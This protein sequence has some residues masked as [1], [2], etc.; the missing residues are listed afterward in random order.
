[1]RI[2]LTLVR[3][4]TTRED[5]TVT[6]DA[7]TSVGELAE[8]L[9]GVDALPPRSR[10]T[11]KVD[12]PGVPDP[13]VLDPQA[14]LG[15]G[16]I[17]SGA[18]VAPTPVPT[19]GTT[20]P[21]HGAGRFGPVP[22]NRSPR[23]QDRYAGITLDVPTVPVEQDPPDFPVI[24]LIAPILMGSAMYSITGSP[25]SLL[26]VLLTPV[27]IVGNYVTQRRRRRRRR[28]RD[29]ARFTER[30]DG[31]AARLVEEQQG[32]R[33]VRGLEAPP[34]DQ[35][36]G[37]A[38]ERGPG[39]WSRR[40]EHW[41]FLLVRLGTGTMPSRCTVDEPSTIDE[42]VFADAV[43]EVLEPHRTLTA[44]PVVESLPDAGAIGVAGDDRAVGPTL[45]ALVVQLTALHSPAEVAVAALVAPERAADLQWLTWLPHTG[46]PHG[47]LTVPQ[48]ADEPRSADAL[49][50]DLER[51]IAQRM[52]SG[53]PRRRGE[54]GVDD[55]AL[56]RGGD[57]GTSSGSR[58]DQVCLPAVVL[59][60]TEGAPTDRAR[61]VQIAERGPD[62]GVFVLW[63]APTVEALP[64]ACRTYVECGDRPRA[65]LVRSGVRVDDLVPERTGPAEAVEYA[66]RM[67]PVEDAGCVVED[68]TDLPRS[69]SLLDLLGPETAEDP[70]VIS[71]R[72]DENRPGLGRA[73]RLTAVVGSAGREPAVLDLRADGPHALVGGT[74][75]A[76]KSEFLQAWV[77]GLATAVGPDDVTFLFVDYKGGSAFAEC[78][79]LPHCVGLVT[80]LT[81][82]LVQRALTSLRAEIVH[83]EQLLHRA[84][85]KDLVELERRGD[86][87]AP[88]ALVIVVDEFAALVGEVPEFVDGMVDIA[89]RGRSLG[90]HL[91]L[92]T[93]RPAGVVRDNLRAN[94]ALRVALR[95]ADPA[96]STDVVGVPDAAHLDPATPGRAVLS[97]G[98]GRTRGFQAAYAGGWTRRTPERDG[99]EVA[100][101]RLGTPVPWERPHV[102]IPDADPGDTD[103]QRLVAVARTAFD[104]T[105]RAVPR[106]PWVAELPD[107]V[108]LA[109][110]GP[111]SRDALVVGL[112]DHPD[113]QVQEPALFLP[114]VDGHLVVLGT[115]GSGRSTVLRTVA[116][117]AASG[118]ETHVYVLDAAAG[119]L[120]P[121]ERLD[122]VAA[123]VPDDDVDR[124]EALWRTLSRELAVRSEAR[125]EGRPVPGPRVLVLVDGF[126][127]FREEAE[128]SG[129]SR[130]LDV[131]RDLLAEGRAVGLHVVLSADRL[132]AIPT[133]ARSLVPRVL[134]LRS[135]EE[136]LL[137]SADVPEAGAPAGRGVLEGVTLQVAVAGGVAGAAAEVASVAAAGSSTTAPALRVLPAVVEPSTV[138]PASGTSGWWGLGV[139]LEP[140]PVELVGTVVVAGPP[141]GGRSNAVGWIAGQIGAD[142]HTVRVG[143]TG[144]VVAG[145]A[146]WDV[147]VADPSEV[148]PAVRD[149]VARA[150]EG[151]VALVVEGI[152]EY[153]QTP[154]DAA[155][156]QAVA[157]LRRGRHLVVA[158]ADTSAWAA[159]WPLIAQVRR[160]RRGLLLQPDPADGDTILRTSLPRGPRTPLPPGRGAWVE[161]RRVTT[162]Q[163]PLLSPP[164][165]HSVVR[166]NTVTAGIME[167]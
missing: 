32:E 83:R 15:D 47:P 122:H 159:S 42:K 7:A 48:L 131:L 104:R 45:D 94:T 72:W 101:R 1:M 145:A 25:L 9:A 44:V 3:P 6:A 124:V 161:R 40:P 110:L 23:V 136:G 35:V 37:Q 92:A 121:L 54:L 58:R 152:D 96:D 10:W 8:A 55:T 102:A 81:P 162:V 67:A 60:V 100:T 107:V 24:A 49:V 119:D 31:L 165:E 38:L 99:V 97:T 123:V 28:A 95:M 56:D 51:L 138:P 143:P 114:A 41:N 76:G 117:S 88:P 4:D 89:Q 142:V 158:E 65:G 73:R 160:A 146:R 14:V 78:T 154:A 167:G 66:R 61:L 2:K 29:V 46:G 120:R 156:V 79:R 34:T 128:A 26:I 109:D 115:G 30:L 126:G 108:A 93:Q 43:A 16:W 91:I 17:G 64:A 103:L 39:L 135:A 140:V 129:R 68:A 125:A 113:R 12:R 106:R 127:T 98:P 87:T 85:A 80:D 59:V 155:L 18:V 33:R 75:G 22:F 5:V 52:P 139:D 84:G 77:L 141:G 90:I 116:A 105:G 50:D 70:T 133:W 166:E 74:S 71:G 53:G 111:A 27:M 132:A 82:R 19:D 63:V 147:E 144:S 36:R 150:S 134:R 153:L 137:A 164:C 157:A 149:L 163:V 112:A 11:V 148:L 21:E 151:P 57:V 20:Y 13:A 62:A 86:G 130:W 69:V 118:P